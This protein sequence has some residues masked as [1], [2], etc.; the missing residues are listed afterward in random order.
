MKKSIKQQILEHLKSGFTLTYGQANTI[1]GSQSG[2][3]RLQEIFKE[4]PDKYHYIK[5]KSA[6]GGMYNVFAER[7]NFH[8][9]RDK[10]IVK[11]WNIF[12]VN[13][14]FMKVGYKTKKEAE[15]QIKKVVR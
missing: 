14:D 8:I 1:T 2:Y 12:G 5:S 9:M 3:R 10:Y 4:N 11:A 7:G 13:D 6:N 15:S